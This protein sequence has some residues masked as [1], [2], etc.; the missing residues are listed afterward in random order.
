[1]PGGP[2]LPSRTSVV[3]LRSNGLLVVSPPPVEPGGLEALD[4]LGAVE[5]VLVPNSFHYLYSAPFLARYP[6]ATFRYAPGLAERDPDL[7]R[8]E[9]LGDAPPP[10]WNGMVE[11]CVLGPVRG[12]SETALFHTP[13]RTL[14]VTD[15]AFHMLRYEGPIDRMIWRLTGIPAGFGPSRTARLFLLGDRAAAATFL[16]KILTWPFERVLVGHGEVLETNAAAEFRRAF[17]A[18]L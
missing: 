18:Y 11:H 2:S 15:L 6:R 17:A 13:T 7:P 5:E 1:M 14:V 8:G 9:E 10:A 3:R 16:R 12:I 4:A